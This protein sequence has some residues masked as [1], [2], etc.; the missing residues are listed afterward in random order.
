VCGV[1][2]AGRIKPIAAS[3][4]LAARGQLPGALGLLDKAAVSALN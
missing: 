4:A 1:E 2:I 3:S